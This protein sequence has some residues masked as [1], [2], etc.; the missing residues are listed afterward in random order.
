MTITPPHPAAPPRPPRP[1]THVFRARKSSAKGRAGATRRLASP[2]KQPLSPTRPRRGVTPHHTFARL[3]AASKRTS[4][5]GWPRAACWTKRDVKREEAL[6]RVAESPQDHSGQEF[7]PSS[8]HVRS[9][10]ALPSTPIPRI[11]NDFQESGIE[12]Q[13]A[14][15]HN[16]CLSCGMELIALSGKIC[17]KP[18]LE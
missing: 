4:R 18:W 6:R 9:Q 10:A 3:R 11:P 15:S 1:S 8:H 17:D 2:R 13:E 14:Q 12:S 5:C 7:H 16:Y